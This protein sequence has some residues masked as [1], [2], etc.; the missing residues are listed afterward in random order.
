[1]SSPAARLLDAF[2][3]QVGWCE[4]GASP[5]SARVLALSRRWLDTDPEALAAL[6]EVDRDPLAAAV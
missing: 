4:A 5:F 1:M 2:D 3:R 6:A